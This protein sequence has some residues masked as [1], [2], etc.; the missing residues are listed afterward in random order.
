[1]EPEGSSPQ[2]R[3]QVTFASVNEAR[4]LRCDTHNEEATR[5]GGS[6]IRLIL[7]TV[8]VI[9]ILVSGLGTI[10]YMSLGFPD[11]HLTAFERETMG[12]WI[13]LLFAN[14][15]MGIV[16]VGWGLQQSI[17]RIL[18]IVFSTAVSIFLLAVPGVLLPNCPRIGACRSLYEAVT[19]SWL[20]DG[21]RF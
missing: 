7:F 21:G 12:L 4:L 17:N 13:A 16:M 10:E 11:G 18:A 6:L 14:A 19:G 9:H 3:W 1:M 8:A 20:D 5:H 2:A 15:S